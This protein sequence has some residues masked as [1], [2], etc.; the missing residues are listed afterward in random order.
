MTDFEKEKKEYLTELKKHADT[1]D[2]MK[3]DNDGSEKGQKTIELI[4]NPKDEKEIMVAEMFL[5]LVEDSYSILDRLFDDK[6]EEIPLEN[7]YGIAFIIRTTNLLKEGKQISEPK[8]APKEAAK[9][10][11]SLTVGFL[12][13][14]D[15][16]IEYIGEKTGFDLDDEDDLE[17]FNKVFEE[18]KKIADSTNAAKKNLE[19]CTMEDLLEAKEFAKEYHK[20]VEAGIKKEEKPHTYTKRKN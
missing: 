8:I 12:T 9:I 11:Y 6:L 7:N 13:N 15:E 1:L 19:D 5:S 4:E 18:S 20:I 14:M 2:K 16:I 10:A 3:N 17:R